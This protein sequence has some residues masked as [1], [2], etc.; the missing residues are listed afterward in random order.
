MYPI[1]QPPW[2]YGRSAQLSREVG[3]FKGEQF[4]IPASQIVLEMW[5]HCDG[6]MVA[7]FVDTLD[8]LVS[9]GKAGWR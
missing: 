2:A 3:C 6:F 9:E 8:I 4:R 7:L 1:F 5:I